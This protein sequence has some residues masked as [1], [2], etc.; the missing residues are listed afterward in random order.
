MSTC[1]K[2]FLALRKY[3]LVS[4]PNQASHAA[5][6]LLRTFNIPYFREFKSHLFT[7]RFSL[8]FILDVHSVLGLGVADTRVSSTSPSDD[9]SGGRGA[10]VSTNPASAQASRQNVASTCTATVNQMGHQEVPPKCGDPVG[11]SEPKAAH[12]K[13]VAPG[14]VSGSLSNGGQSNGTSIGSSG[15][16]SGKSKSV[17][18][19][20]VRL[21]CM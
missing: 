12:G 20:G 21:I 18:L 19:L 9:N 16:V 3:V 17:L 10:P 2:F 4:A 7:L 14:T 13:P 1:S 6:S 15:A 11:S 5:N 8:L